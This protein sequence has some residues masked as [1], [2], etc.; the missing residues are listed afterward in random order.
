MSKSVQVFDVRD[1]RRAWSIVATLPPGMAE[2]HQGL[3]CDAE[4]DR[5]FAVAGQLGPSCAPPTASAWMLDLNTMT[6]RRIA[7]LPLA[8]HGPSAAVI[9]GHLHVFGGTDETRWRAAAEHWFIRLDAAGDPVGDWMVASYG[10]P[11]SGAHAVVATV[12]DTFL[13]YMGAVDDICA[14]PPHVSL[15]ECN[16]LCDQLLDRRTTSN[17][18]RFAYRCRV[19]VAVESGG[20]CWEAFD[21]P[22]SKISAPNALEIRDANNRTGLLLV[23]GREATPFEE[24]ARA[25]IRVVRHVNLLDVHTLRWTAYPPLPVGVK[26]GVLV[27]HNNDVIVL[28]LTRL[29]QHQSGAVLPPKVMLRAN[30]TLWVDVVQ[31]LNQC[32]RSLR[33]RRLVLDGDSDAAFESARLGRN[34]AHSVTKRPLAVA[35]ASSLR[36]LQAIAA[37]AS[38]ADVPL[39]GRGGRH[40]FSGES[41][42]ERGIVVDIGYNTVRVVGTTLTVGAGATL[43]QVMS[44]LLRHNSSL[45]LPMGHC[46]TVGMSGST[47]VGGHGFLARMHGLTSD[48][49]VAMTAVRKTDGVALTIN[50][51]SSNTHLLRLARGGGGD[52]YPA[53]VWELVY[54]LAVL[55]DVR[56]ARIRVDVH[57]DDAAATMALWQSKANTFPDQRLFIESWF[58]RSVGQYARFRVMGLYIAQ[59][60]A[61]ADAERSLRVAMQQ[62]VPSQ[63]RVLGESLANV[64]LA[65]YFMDVAGVNSTREL[66]SGEHGWDLHENLNQWWARNRWSGRSIG[67]YAPAPKQF[68][69]RVTNWLVYDFDEWR[70]RN[71]IPHVDRC[72]FEGKPL[73]GAVALGTR[74]SSAFPHHQAT[75]WVLFSC[76]FNSGATRAEEGRILAAT[77]ALKIGLLSELTAAHKPFSYAGYAEVDDPTAV[78]AI[79]PHA[80][81]RRCA[82]AELCGPPML[83][84]PTCADG[85]LRDVA[86]VNVSMSACEWRV[87]GDRCV[88][89]TPLRRV[90]GFDLMH[91]P[92]IAVVLTGQL[93]RTSLQQK[94]ERILTT[95]NLKQF[96]FV[97]LAALSHSSAV[98]RKEFGAMGHRASVRSLSGLFHGTIEELFAMVPAASADALMYTYGQRD[99]ALDQ[100]PINDTNEYLLRATAPNKRG[101]AMS[102]LLQF[103]GL[104][105]GL[106]L[107][108][109]YERAVGRAVSFVL[110]VRDDEYLSRDVDFKTSVELLG[111]A[112]DMLANLCGAWR[113]VNDRTW[114]LKRHSAAFDAVRLGQLR[115]AYKP[116]GE[117]DGNNP[118]WLLRKALEVASVRVGYVAPCHF[119]SFSLR[120]LTDGGLC[121]DA[122]TVTAQILLYKCRVPRDID[123]ADL[124]LLSSCQTTDNPRGMMTSEGIA[125]PVCPYLPN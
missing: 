30:L 12:D 42:C 92:V 110:R 112:V 43:G 45:V 71:N 46:A 60:H 98:F 36:E 44:E 72:Y 113:G 75:S 104:R 70:S 39:C 16:L 6:F 115:E 47:L 109:T 95:D 78:V 10:V 125:L 55:G 14:Q 5:I 63:A 94:L 122:V 18:V 96:S 62:V 88:G 22:D 53:V 87:L 27:Q 21:V 67:L 59:T 57:V 85:R 86:C 19:S 24:A 84:V 51:T 81:L 101:A 106:A 123:V 93:S 74:D 17:A 80:Q 119:A 73:G 28:D 50:A 105:R 124:N 38:T 56:I 58:D 61:W 40:G 1:D 48:H 54:D 23:G 77:R 65:Q 91:K 90:R 25:P 89:S 99:V 20:N 108:A 118:E 79:S 33:L 103:D 107:V 120:N 64:S 69:D 8:R 3:A 83:E 66:A 76:F 121:F 7:D 4:H 13:L 41:G 68:F 114:F 37:C 102:N 116:F 32:L 15:R 26:A 117:E 11:E 31:R 49:L 100:L 2:S 34:R 111:P 97:L 52:R 9:A 35:T 29:G 82:E